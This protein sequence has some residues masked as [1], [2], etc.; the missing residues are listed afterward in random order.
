MKCNSNTLRALTCSKNIQ[1]R[2]TFCCYGEFWG[3]VRLVHRAEI[4][5]SHVLEN[6]HFKRIYP[7]HVSKIA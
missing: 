5:L 4:S 2:I 1:Q 6:K 7:L 3:S